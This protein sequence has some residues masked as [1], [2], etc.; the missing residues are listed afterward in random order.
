MDLMVAIYV[1]H[2]TR[3]EPNGEWLAWCP[4]LDVSTVGTTR[5]RAIAAVREA[6]QLWI[7]TCTKRGTLIAAMKEVGFVRAL[8]GVIG[9]DEN[10]LIT[11]GGT[12]TYARPID[13]LHSEGSSKEIGCLAYESPPAGDEHRRFQFEPLEVL[14]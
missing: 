12:A 9:G 10:D 7:E 2:G 5:A 1:H 14:A 4:C 6:I 11:I 3:R 13:Y 8:D